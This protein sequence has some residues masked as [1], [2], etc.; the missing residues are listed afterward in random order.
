MLCPQQRGDKTG[1]LNKVLLVLKDVD[2][3]FCFSALIRGIQTRFFA[4]GSCLY[5][6]D[7][8]EGRIR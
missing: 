2:I 4:S 8:G 3:L 7:Y 6:A 5:G 1:W